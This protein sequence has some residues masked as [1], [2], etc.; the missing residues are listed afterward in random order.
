MSDTPTPETQAAKDDAF[1]AE[2]LRR[3]EQQ[4]LPAQM[5][6][7]NAI[8]LANAWRDCDNMLSRLTLGDPIT[9]DYSEVRL[10][11]WTQQDRLKDWA[12]QLGFP[13]MLDPDDHGP[14]DPRLMVPRLTQGAFN[15]LD[16]IVKSVAPLM[17]LSRRHKRPDLGHRLEPPS[18]SLRISSMT[19]WHRKDKR[20]FLSLSRGLGE[21][22][23][24]LFEL[25]ADADAYIL[26]NPVPMT[27]E[28]SSKTEGGDETN[29]H[30]YA[31]KPAPSR[32]EELGEKS[33]VNPGG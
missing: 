31:N 24:L 25:L 5:Q 26:L 13:Q 3:F 30:G 12:R 11:I 17:P 16:D 8:A 2:T 6:D 19:R 22:I 9:S 15:F 20:A 27:V 14:L 28:G 21:C 10:G 7:N 29:H 1:V 32:I 4:W 33:R 18:M 23:N